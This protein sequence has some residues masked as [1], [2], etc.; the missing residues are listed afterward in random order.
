MNWTLDSQHSEI[1]QETHTVYGFGAPVYRVKD[2]RQEETLA[3]VSAQFDKTYD[4]HQLVY[5]FDIQ[6]SDLE[7]A[8]DTLY[9]NSVNPDTYTRAV[10]KVNAERYGFY[11]QDHITL[12]DERLTL[13]PGIRYDSFESKPVL[14]E[15]YS[16]PDLAADSLSKHS[17]DKFTFRLG[18]VYEISENTSVF[19][20]YSQGF[21]APEPID[22]YYASERNYGPGNHFLTLPNAN[23]E[24]EE[25]DAY[26]LGLRIKGAV[27]NIEGV[28]FYNRYNNFIDDVSVDSDIN[29][30]SFDGVTQAQNI[31]EANIKG[32]ELRGSLWL[33]DAIQAPTGSS[34]QFSV[35]YAKGENKTNN[36]PL[37]S[38]A[39][40][41][42]VIGFGY[43]APSNKWGGNLN[44]TLVKG[45]EVTEL[46]D[47]NDFATSGYGSV[48][49]NAYYNLGDK[50]VVN[51]NLSNL[52]DKEFWVY[53]DMRNKNA[54]DSDLDKF[55][56][57]GRNLSLSM[58]YQF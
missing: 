30:V 48:D 27:G 52:N 32:A 11:L 31:E 16:A 45:K 5:G 38:I 44:W 34:L 23:L 13:T 19:A 6:K 51:A 22:L 24:A 12:M 28:V 29:G 50:L 40:L 55:T 4:S 35:A 54:D 43:D 1:D 42:V 39:P 53:D 58:K 56:R 46:A 9:P 2:Y 49:L 57:P 17:S 26:E 47:E 14:D 36:R 37:S 3:K 15:Q 20:Q 18:S 7:N 10:P 8:Q 33:D 41:K 21:K 25:S